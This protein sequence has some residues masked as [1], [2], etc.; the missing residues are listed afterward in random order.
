[1][2]S[3]DQRIIFLRHRRNV[4]NEFGMLNTVRDLVMELS[5]G[6]I[7]WIVWLE[8]AVCNPDIS[9]TIK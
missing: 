9:V 3:E 6:A 1:M 7:K 4:V 2:K 5:K 8:D